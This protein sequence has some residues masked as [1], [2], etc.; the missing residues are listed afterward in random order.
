MQPIVGA[1]CVALLAH[2]VIAF[3]I[4]RRALALAECLELLL[5]RVGLPQ[6]ADAR[7]LLLQATTG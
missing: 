1:R 2:Y 6:K 7:D 5:V 3:D 4:V